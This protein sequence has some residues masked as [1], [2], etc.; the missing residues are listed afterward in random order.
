L[1]EIVSN[2]SRQNFSLKERVQKLEMNQQILV[3]NQYCL[4]GF[5]EESIWIVN[6]M[7][8]RLDTLERNNK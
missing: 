7:R 6:E 4:Q 5:Q 2:L 3:N 8:L 1:K